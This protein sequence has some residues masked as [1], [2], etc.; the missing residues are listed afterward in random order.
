MF[1]QRNDSRRIRSTG[2]LLPAELYLQIAD[3]N[4]ASRRSHLKCEVQ[5]RLSDIRFQ[6]TRSFNA[7]CDRQHQ[8]I[9]SGIP[10]TP[11]HSCPF[12]DS[13]QA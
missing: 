2:D 10:I 12:N 7:N 9:I 3:Q 13:S 6:T 4:A 1:P 8:M 5:R 11:G